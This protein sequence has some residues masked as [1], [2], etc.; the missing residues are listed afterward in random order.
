LKK[1]GPANADKIENSKP[2]TLITASL[3]AD[4]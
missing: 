2:P 4:Y 3:S 1:S